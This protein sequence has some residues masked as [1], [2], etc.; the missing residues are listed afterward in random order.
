M[1]A[2]VALLVAALAVSSVAALYTE[3]EY[4]FLFTSF[5][6]QWGKEYEHELFFTKYNTFKANLDFVVEHNSW[7]RSYTLAVNQFGDL[8][9]EEFGKTYCGYKA[10]AERNEEEVNFNGELA[11]ELD[12]VAKGAVTPVKDQGQCGSCW[13]F[14]ATGAIEGAVQ[15]K[16]K[17]LTSV[18]EQELVDCA[19]SSGNQG[20]N[21]GL[22]DYAFQWVIKNKGIAS[23]AAYPYT[24]RDGTCKKV[25]STSTISGFKDVPSKNEGATGLLGA[26]NLGPVSIA[27]EADKSVFQFYHDGVLDNTGCGTQLDHGI[28]VTGYGTLS[29]KDYWAVKNS[30]GASWGKNGYI[31]LVRNKNQCGLAQA[32]SYA[33]A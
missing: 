19:G 23:E 25:A 8:T 12:W 1:K 16:G 9:N 26:V 33:I 4:Q 3:S 7:N 10:N 30:W 6:A 18:S 2:C 15:I 24:A 17:G 29:G 14:S 11:A 20:C 28:L 32:A 27:V 31:Y 5:V 22:M 21:G 13:A